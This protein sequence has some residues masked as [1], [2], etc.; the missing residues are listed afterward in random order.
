MPPN[1]V[2]VRMYCKI[3]CD[4]FPDNGFSEGKKATGDDI[5]E[6]LLREL[7]C[8][9]DPDTA[10]TILGDHAIW[11]L[12]SN[13][14]F[15]ILQVGDHV[16]EWT[17]GGSSWERVYAFLHLLHKKNILSHEQYNHLIAITNESSEAFDDM[18]QIPAYLKAK[19]SGQEWVKRWTDTKETMKKMISDAHE[20]LTE[21][22]WQVIR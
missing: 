21:G 7:G 14:K 13:E 4:E 6:F 11:Y 15:G 19:H 18:Y 12:G 9:S 10:D 1:K 22:G 3:F 17:C 5:Y 8:F 2:L 20:I 16:S